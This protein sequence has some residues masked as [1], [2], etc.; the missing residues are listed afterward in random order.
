MC[1]D[2]IDSTRLRNGYRAEGLAVL[3]GGLSIPSLIQDFHKIGLVKLSGI[4]TRLPIYYA[5]GFLI[6]LGLLLSLEPWHS[7]S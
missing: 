1:K 7:Y 4:R 3:L 2:P 6:L 5:A